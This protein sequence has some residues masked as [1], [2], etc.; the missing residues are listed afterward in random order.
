MPSLENHYYQ[1]QYKY[2]VGD[3]ERWYDR[4]RNG[5]VYPDN[6]E[7]DRD[8]ECEIKR[9]VDKLNTG[10]GNQVEFRAAKVRN[11]TIIEPLIS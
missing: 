8:A 9:R 2:M 6:Y 11:I 7:S 3:L 5:R 1:I 4:Q 10:K